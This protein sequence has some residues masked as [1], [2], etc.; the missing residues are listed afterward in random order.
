MPR[1]GEKI[2]RDDDP[3]RYEQLAAARERAAEVRKQRA[4][5]KRRLK[6]AENLDVRKKIDALEDYERER[7]LKQQATKQVDTEPSV[8]SDADSTDTEPEPEPKPV[9]KPKRRKAKKKVQRIVYE[10]ESSS[11]EEEVIVRRRKPH[12]PLRND[13]QQD[14]MNMMYSQIF[15]GY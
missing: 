7:A 1:K 15:G 5:E 3:E 10:E 13:P 11:S 9:P 6:E 4:E 8:E 14:R 2:S 12:H